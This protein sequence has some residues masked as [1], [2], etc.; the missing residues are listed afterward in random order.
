MMRC[1]TQTIEIEE[2]REK[3]WRSSPEETTSPE[4]RANSSIDGDYEV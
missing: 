4:P 2:N 1:C 3:E